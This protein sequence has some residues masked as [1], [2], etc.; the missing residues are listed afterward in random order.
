MRDLKASALL[1]LEITPLADEDLLGIWLYTAETWSIGQADTY[2]DSLHS[3]LELLRSMP[4]I[5]R[6]RVNL[7]RPIR[8]YPSSSHLIAYTADTERVIILRVLAQKQDW[9]AILST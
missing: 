7:T 3:S 2:I 8:I 4:E 6:A 1:E 9:Q 5:V